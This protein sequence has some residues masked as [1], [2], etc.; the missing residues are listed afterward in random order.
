MLLVCY[1]SLEVF[2][3][4]S[5]VPNNVSL[6]VVDNQISAD[7]IW[8]VGNSARIFKATMANRKHSEQVQFIFKN[9]TTGNGWEV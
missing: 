6:C 2:D 1:Y 8:S 3:G 4:I 9:S 5:Y 7:N